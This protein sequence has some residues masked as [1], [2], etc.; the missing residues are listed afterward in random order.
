MPVQ[1]CR[2]LA[3]TFRGALD[4]ASVENEP[5]VPVRVIF[6]VA[7]RDAQHYVA[8]PGL[9]ILHLRI[10]RFEPVFLGTGVVATV[11]MGIGDPVEK[12]GDQSGAI[13]GL[14][15]FGLRAVFALASKLVLHMA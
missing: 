10:P 4:R 15:G 9:V 3:G 5:D 8:S 7:K 2:A 1:S 14:D 12:I 6:L 11:E 13:E